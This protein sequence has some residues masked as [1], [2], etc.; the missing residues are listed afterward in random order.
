MAVQG[1]SGTSEE[2]GVQ[3]LKFLG[4][5]EIVERA[6]STAGSL[7]RSRRFNSSAM[8]RAAGSSLP[9]VFSAPFADSSGERERRQRINSVRWLPILA[10]TAARASVSARSGSANTRY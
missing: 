2:L 7:T 6:S 5:R 10:L 1:Y 3:L 9:R 8:S 4:V